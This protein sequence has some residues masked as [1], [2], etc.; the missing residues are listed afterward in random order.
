MKPLDLAR[1]FKAGESI[2]DLANAYGEEPVY[3]EALLRAYM[4][5]FEA[6]AQIK[7]EEFE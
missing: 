7:C 1:R 4:V 6:G 5:G 3:V 2:E